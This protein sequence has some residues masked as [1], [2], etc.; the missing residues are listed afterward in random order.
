MKAWPDANGETSWT[1]RYLAYL[2]SHGHLG[3]LGFFSFEHY[4]FAS[5]ED[6]NLQDN[7]VREPHLMSNIVSI[8]RKDGLPAGLP[9]FVTETNYS[10]NETY[11]AQQIAGALWYGDMAA[12]LLS[13]GGA[14]AFL[15]EY[16]P[17]PLSRS[18]PCP[19][20]GTYGILLGNGKYQ[21]QAPLSQFFGAQMLSGVWAEPVDAAHML[22][23]ASIS[24]GEGLVTAYPVLRPDAA[25]AVLLVNRDLAN[26]H[27]AQV[28]FNFPGGPAYFNG[29]VTQT[30]FGEA[31]YAW[32]IH[33]W[34]SHPNPDGPPAT[35]NQSGGAGT[36]Y[37]LPAGSLTVLKGVVGQ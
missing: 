34:K 7:L 25:W 16:E 10:Q 21:A 28:V 12:T 2:S 9:I 8:W 24:G 29:T 30:V 19:N 5:C 23:G 4:P 35:S 1:K 26:P 13:A 6:A 31:Q 15:Y 18:Y 20:V 36:T 11:A 37:T 27:Q 14:G 3:D 32:V 17:I 22:Y 33:G